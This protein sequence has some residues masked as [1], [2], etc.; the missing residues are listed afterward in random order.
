MLSCGITEETQWSI[1]TAKS[2]VSLHQKNVNSLSCSVKLFLFAPLTPPLIDSD[3]E[4][5][6]SVTVVKTNVLHGS[7]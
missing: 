5:V 3:S 6:V 4:W 1:Q 7:R 2:L